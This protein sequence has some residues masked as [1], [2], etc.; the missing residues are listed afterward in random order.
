MRLSAR[1]LAPA[2]AIACACVLACAPA[3]FAFVRLP[4][5]QQLALRESWLTQR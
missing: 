2:C 4:L 5:S 1:A 3:P